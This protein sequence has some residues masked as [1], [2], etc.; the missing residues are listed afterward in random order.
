MLRRTLLIP[1]VLVVAASCSQAEIAEDE[2]T[3]ATTPAATSTV[4]ASTTTAPTTTMAPTT[5]R[6][7]VDDGC[8]EPLASPGDYEKT[9]VTGETERSYWVVVPESYAD[10][11][12]APLYLHLASGGGDHDPMM[13]GW[14]P[15]LDDIDGVMAIV[16]TEQ[17]ATT[18][19]LVAI[20]D[21]VSAD[22]CIDS[23]R[24]HVMATSSSELMAV[25]MACEASDRVASFTAGIGTSVPL[26]GCDPERPVPL[27][28]FTGN[29]DRTFVLEL[30]EKWS[31][32]NG[33]APEPVADD[34]GSG[35]TRRTYQQ[36]Q[37]DV[38]LYD[39]LTLGHAWP[40]HESKGPGA[41]FTAEYEEVD[42]LEEALIFF[43]ENPMP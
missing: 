13:A 23:R 32:F 14:R 38:V 36:C 31:E 30:V 26:L 19:D 15:Y 27:L 7:V 33:C 41:A 35:V 2:S 4:V 9:N 12:P 17:R 10:A 16:N 20:V 8:D 39:I 37:A 43:A 18:A 42:Y 21:E 1:A 22:Y 6:A 29:P 28:S 34:L 3:E 5:T 24:V 11:A 25:K 40:V